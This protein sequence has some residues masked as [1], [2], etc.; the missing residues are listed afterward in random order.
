MVRAI[1]QFAPVAVTIGE[2]E[3]RIGIEF[4][5]NVALGQRLA[6]Q[7]GAADIAAMREARREQLLKETLE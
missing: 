2:F 7:I 6:Q 5:R 1:E 4:D 3:G